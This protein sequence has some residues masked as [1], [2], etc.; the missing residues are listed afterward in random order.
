MIA[1][2]DVRLIDMSRDE[3]LLLLDLVLDSLGADEI[4]P[5]VPFVPPAWHLEIL[6]ERIAE[7]DADPSIMIPWEA[8]K[9]ELLSGR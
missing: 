6:R 2:A 8:V 4:D 1:A 9:A 7:I 5:S 3:R